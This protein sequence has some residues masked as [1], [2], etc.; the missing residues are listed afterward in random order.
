MEVLYTCDDNYV[1]ILRTSLASLLINNKL[2]VNLRITLIGSKVSLKNIQELE[3][4]CGMYNRKFIYFEAP[5]FQLD[6][7]S[8]SRWPLI[9]YIRLF[10]AN[11]LDYDRVL[12]LDCD[13]IVNGKLDFFES[14]IFKDGI[15]IAG[16][17]DLLNENYKKNLNIPTDDYYLNAGVLLLNLK[18][19]R[20]INIVSE[21]SEFL[22][23]YSFVCLYADQD[24]MNKIFEG[25]KDL[26]PLKFNLITVV[27][28]FDFKNF[29][30]L[31][32][33]NDFYSKEEIFEAKKKPCIIHYTTCLNIVR[34][35]YSNS[36]H[37]FAEVFEKYL[38]FANPNYI[39]KTFKA[40]FLVKLVLL[41]PRV[42]SFNAI[43]IV[44]AYIKPILRRKK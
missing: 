27:S 9:S 40:N 13:L 23:N 31:R 28:Q 37:V 2:I 38:Y 32:R 19:I 15:L 29:M 21:I 6:K 41:F 42:I 8:R 25:K 1:W 26:L 18:E 33:S 4:L 30:R 35:W 10:A 39:K 20:K 34:P 5:T 16:V 44:H 24:A 22:N 14:Y 11:I 7:A 17:K 36:N 43:G 3:K 12:Y